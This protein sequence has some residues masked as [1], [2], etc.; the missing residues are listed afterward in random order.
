V[1][2]VGGERLGAEGHGVL[3]GKRG[4]HQGRRDGARL[5]ESGAGQEAAVRRTGNVRLGDAIPR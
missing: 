3:A 1:A 4:C 5:L 2:E